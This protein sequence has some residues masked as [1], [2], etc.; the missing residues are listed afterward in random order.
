MLPPL[1]PPSVQWGAFDAPDAAYETYEAC[2]SR[3]V[4]ALRTNVSPAPSDYQLRDAAM[5]QLSDSQLQLEY[6]RHTEAY[7]DANTPASLRGMAEMLV[8]KLGELTNKSRASRMQLLEQMQQRSVARSRS[9]SE[10]EREVVALEQ[11]ERWNEHAYEELRSMLAAALRDPDTQPELFRRLANRRE[12]QLVLMTRAEA[13]KLTHAQMTAWGTNGL[14]PH[15]LRAVLH[16]VSHAPING[17]PAQQFKDQLTAKVYD[18]PPP[19][20]TAFAASARRHTSL[21]T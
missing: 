14:Q 13:A 20:G 9:L 18:L 10:V 16:A 3:I 17:R 2:L 1:P 11:Q 19:S 21:K 5:L 6:M 12:L 4:E 15:E 7:L 8:I